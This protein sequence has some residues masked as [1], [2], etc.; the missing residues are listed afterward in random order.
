MQPRPADDRFGYRQQRERS[1]QLA[2]APLQAAASGFLDPPVKICQTRRLRAAEMAIGREAI[3]APGGKMSQLS[4]LRLKNSLASELKRYA[5]P[6]DF[7]ILA[8]D[9]VGFIL[10]AYI[11][12][13]GLYWFDL[14]WDSLAYH[15][16]FAGLRAGII[17]PDEY[18]LPW[19]MTPRF[20]GFPVAV[21]YAQGWLWKITG[22]PEAT[23]LIST[24]S[25]LIVGIYARA[26][27][28]IGLIWTLLI[29]LAVPVTETAIN[30]SYTDLWTN[31]FF[32]LHLLAGVKAA[33]SPKHYLVHAIVSCA[34]LAVAVNSKEQFFIMGGA[35]YAL[36]VLERM[37][38]LRRIGVSEW[39]RSREGRDLLIFLLAAP[40][41]FYC[42]VKNL[43]VFGNP[44]YPVSVTV[45]GHKFPGPEGNSWWGPKELEHVPQPIVYFL[46]QMDLNGTDMRS[47]GY[48]LGQGD[49][50]GNHGPGDRMGGSLGVL[51]LAST[52]YL[53]LCLN[54]LDNFRAYRAWIVGFVM[55]VGLAAVF[56]GSNEL[57]YFSFINLV[58]LFAGIILLNKGTREGDRASEHFGIAF[59]MLILSAAI[60]TSSLNEFQHFRWPH[61]AEAKNV[62]NNFDTRTKIL[63]LLKTSDTI[64]Y[65]RPDQSAILY[66]PALN[67]K[68]VGRTYHFVWTYGP[69]E[70][71][72]GSAI[73]K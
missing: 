67:A 28:R 9:A 45:A 16:P 42:P 31:A 38:R 17:K 25:I 66:S 11:S 34:A 37:S 20:A 27:F 7:R 44:I 36:F 53:V 40:A 43:I 63:Q 68:Y 3:A 50:T 32:V 72:K 14:H 23:S 64:C 33:R 10:I 30:A 2:L 46:S 12:C 69:Q 5:A 15:M 61:N 39:F 57:R 60:Y 13:I 52:M 24:L 73:L 8:E 55:L 49:E 59:K 29:F 1:D 19:E 54:R 71:P 58:I 70:C 47:G 56:P 41:I 18:V 22:R 6:A 51:L 4:Y 48:A 65:P 35:S 26:A 62:L 21:D